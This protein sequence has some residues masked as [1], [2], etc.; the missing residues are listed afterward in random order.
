MY[1]HCMDRETEAQKCHVTCIGPRGSVRPV[2]EQICL[3]LKPTFALLHRAVPSQHVPGSLRGP[4][5][6]AINAQETQKTR[7]CLG[8]RL[9]QGLCQAAGFKGGT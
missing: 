5:S 7:I 4:F 6:C 9:S 2:L 8:D 3:A 1:S